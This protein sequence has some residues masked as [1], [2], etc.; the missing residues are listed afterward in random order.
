MDLDGCNKVTGKYL[1]GGVAGCK[2]PAPLIKD[3][4]IEGTVQMGHQNGTSRV[5]KGVRTLDTI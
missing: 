3:G 5:S 4:E 1:K 2:P